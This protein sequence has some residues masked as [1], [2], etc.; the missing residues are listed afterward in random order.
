MLKLHAL[1]YLEVDQEDQERYLKKKV[2]IVFCLFKADHKTT[3]G[4]S[5]PPYQ[6]AVS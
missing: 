6:I 2:E 3:I 4:P 1:Y 5:F